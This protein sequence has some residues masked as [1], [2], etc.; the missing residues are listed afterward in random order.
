MTPV[1]DQDTDEVSIHFR[2]TR[3]PRLWAPQYLPRHT[4]A[5]CGDRAN[6]A[7]RTERSSSSSS[8]T[9]RRKNIERAFLARIDE[10]DK[11]WK[12]SASELQLIRK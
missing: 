11:N 12:F 8:S 3:K 2:N 10:P 7:V 1:S 9:S 5:I 6:D 4:I